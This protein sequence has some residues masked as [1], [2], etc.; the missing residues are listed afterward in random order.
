MARVTAPQ[1]TCLRGRDQTH[2]ALLFA[3]PRQE[4]TNK[5]CVTEAAMRDRRA[6]LLYANKMEI[7]KSTWTRGSVSLQHQP[8]GLSARQLCFCSQWQTYS[9]LIR[10][11]KL[12]RMAS[13]REQL[14][15]RHIQAVYNLSIQTSTTK[16]KVNKCH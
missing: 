6:E 9:R 2:R 14:C 15:D 7:Q 16:P 11:V 10:S 5:L 3:I 4:L 13:A 12:M 8:D 1:A